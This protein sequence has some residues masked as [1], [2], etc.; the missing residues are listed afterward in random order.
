MKITIVGVGALGSNLVLSL[1]NIK[2]ELKVIDFDR[3]ERKNT[4]IQF[5]TLMSVGKNK[6]EALKQAM[7]GLFGVKIE[8]VPH[9]LTADN[10]NQLLGDADL[11]IDCLDNGES[12]RLIQNY[13]RAKGVACLHGALAPDGGFGRSIWD[14][15]FVIDD[16]T[17]MGT[18][19]CENGE[20]LPFITTVVSYMAASVQRYLKAGKKIGFQV[21][22]NGVVV[23]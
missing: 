5:H 8:A 20:H 1:R 6:T 13:V 4:M 22:P 9:R 11:I 18:A 3:V 23:I 16:E 15:S 10:V 14:E 7:Q 21:H 2:A 12:R 17:G 19:T